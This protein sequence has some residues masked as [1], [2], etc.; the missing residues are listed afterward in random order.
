LCSPG[1]PDERKQLIALEAKRI[2]A[3]IILGDL[4]AYTSFDVRDKVKQITVPV[5]L[6]TGG[7]DCSCTPDNVRNTERTLECPKV[8]GILPGVGHFPHME[9]PEQF[10]EA[11]LRLWAEVW[12]LYVPS[13]QGSGEQTQSSWTE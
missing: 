1:T 12:K 9:A 4:D 7:D 10:S 6:I 2:P 13:E 8:L 3:E 11:L 5:I